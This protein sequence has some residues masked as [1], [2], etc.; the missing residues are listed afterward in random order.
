MKCSTPASR[1]R[2]LCGSERSGIPDDLTFP[3]EHLLNPSIALPCRGDGIEAIHL[4]AGVDHFFVSG[5]RA[6][7]GRLLVGLRIE[8]DVSDFAYH[9]DPFIDLWRAGG[10]YGRFGVRPSLFAATH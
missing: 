6:V 1:V 9:Y 5:Q 2:K 10:R 3:D 4:G 8:F 7:A